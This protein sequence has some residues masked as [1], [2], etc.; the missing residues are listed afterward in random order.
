[1]CQSLC[2]AVTEEDVAPQEEEDLYFAFA[3]KLGD[4]AIAHL[5]LYYVHTIDLPILI[6]VTII[7]HV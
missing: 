3:V 6:A 4:Y 2:L 7:V 1:M 5:R